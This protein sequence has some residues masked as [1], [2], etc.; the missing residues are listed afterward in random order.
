[1]DLTE[2]ILQSLA[3]NREFIKTMD[4]TT[5]WKLKKSWNK[6]MKWYK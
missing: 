1:M 5:I 3:D 4:I 2:K 6:I